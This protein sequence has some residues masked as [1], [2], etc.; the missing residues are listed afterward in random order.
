MSSI[1]DVNLTASN[2]HDGTMV[3]LIGESYNRPEN[4]NPSEW[5]G[6]MTPTGLGKF[7]F[8]N[9]VLEQPLDFSSIQRWD[10]WCDIDICKICEGGPYATTYEVVFEWGDTKKY[11]YVSEICLRC[12]NLLN[13]NIIRNKAVD[14][15]WIREDV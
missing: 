15:E 4:R 10:G 3:G 6:V 11:E 14:K 7:V 2:V 9:Y 12:L 8:K 5:D 13:N 1:A